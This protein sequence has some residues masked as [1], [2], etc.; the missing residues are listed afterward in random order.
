MSDLQNI[1]CTSIIIL[2]NFIEYIIMI[3]ILFSIFNVS[4]DNPIMRFLYALT[5]PILAPA[6]ALIES[7][8]KRPMMIDF[9][10]IIVWLLLDIVVSLL[11][12]LVRFIII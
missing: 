11:C 6:R 12:Q 2:G 9:S 8:F 5:E 10:P 7:V 1:L 4:Y 3:R